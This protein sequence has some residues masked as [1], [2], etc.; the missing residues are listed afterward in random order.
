MASILAL[1]MATY[2]FFAYDAIDDGFRILPFIGILN[3]LILVFLSYDK[4]FEGH[5]WVVV[6]HA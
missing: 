3:D 5:H 4:F 1:G 2:F 6:E